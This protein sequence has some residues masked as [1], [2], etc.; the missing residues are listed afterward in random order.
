[1]DH[2]SVVSFVV[3]VNYL[4][5]LNVVTYKREGGGGVL[6]IYIKESDYIL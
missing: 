3:R 4:K 2:N 5:L 6:P 1:M